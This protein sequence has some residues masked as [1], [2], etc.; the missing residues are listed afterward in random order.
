MPLHGNAGLRALRCLALSIAPFIGAPAARNR[1]GLDTDE[2]IRAG[3]AVTL[4]ALPM[5]LKEIAKKLTSGDIPTGAL[6]VLAIIA[7]ILAVR[8]AGRVFKFLLFVVALGLVAAA[9]WWHYH[10]RH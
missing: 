4:Q 9:V 3:S 8:S 7:V 2:D 10:N 6:G 1:L 5:D